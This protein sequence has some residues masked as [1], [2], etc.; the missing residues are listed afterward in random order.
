MGD[1][2][3]LA[4]VSAMTVSRALRRDASVSART[5]ARVLEVVDEIGYVPDKAAGSLSS[6]RSGLVA[7]IFPTLVLPL[8]AYV[9]KG[10]GETIS[11]SGLELQIAASDY[12]ADREEEILRSMLR[13]RPEAVAIAGVGHTAKTARL[14]QGAGIPVVEFLDGADPAI[15][16]LIGLDLTAV[17][18]ATVEYLAARGRKRLAV[19]SPRSDAGRRAERRVQSLAEAARAHG[20]PEP[21]VFQQG[22]S[23]QPVEQGARSAQAMIASGES[24]DALI[25]MT[26]YAAIGAVRELENAGVQVPSDMAVFGFGD[27]EVARYVRPS[28]TTVGFNPAA[29]GVEI[30]KII[31]SAL[32]A[33][34]QG[35]ERQTYR[36]MLDFQIYERESA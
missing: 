13:R 33:A 14:L 22:S 16:S 32:D 12:S 23:I 36:L 27:C 6:G 5:R 25:L 8:F 26:D 21:A 30:G 2:A 1:V 11:Q 17:S 19:A 34:R 7:V 3:R 9:A 15:D 24:Y 35:A 28:I 4:G 20:L 29:A 31:L 18:R 10:L